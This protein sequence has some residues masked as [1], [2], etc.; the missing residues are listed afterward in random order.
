MHS[1]NY[2]L[3]F[4]INNMHPDPDQTLTINYIPSDGQGYDEM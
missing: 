1:A 4:I 3:I 2:I